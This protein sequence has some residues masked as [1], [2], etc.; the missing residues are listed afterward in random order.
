[1]GY[2]WFHKSHSVSAYF[3]LKSMSKLLS[4]PHNEAVE[5]TLTTTDSVYTDDRR[6]EMFMKLY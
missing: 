5:E 3:I 2:F 4:T 6:I 1:M